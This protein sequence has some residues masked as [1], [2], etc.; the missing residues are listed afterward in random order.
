MAARA[1]ST[2]CHTSRLGAKLMIADEAFACKQAAERTGRQ[3]S[4]CEFVPG[5]PLQRAVCLTA[6]HVKIKCVRHGHRNLTGHA[7]PPCEEVLEWN[8][9]QG[10]NGSPGRR[11]LA[12]MRWQTPFSRALGPQGQCQT[13]SPPAYAGTSFHQLQGSRAGRC[14]WL[15]LLPHRGSNA[16]RDLS[17]TQKAQRVCSR[18]AA[19]V[20]AASAAALSHS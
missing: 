2:P 16:D 14:V 19:R 11:M 15:V 3:V 7:V 12:T 4:S 17:S 5:S 20:F 8:R 1:P 10:G 13:A 18:Y 9:G 6:L